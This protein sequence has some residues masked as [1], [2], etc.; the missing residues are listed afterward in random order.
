MM[1]IDHPSTSDSPMTS[2]QQTL[3]SQ[4]NP[5]KPS[6]PSQQDDTSLSTTKQSESGTPIAEPSNQQQSG[7]GAGAIV[8]HESPATTHQSADETVALSMMQVDHPV[9]SSST[10]D[11]DERE[12]QEMLRE[13]DE[14]GVPQ[15]N[16]LQDIEQDSRQDASKK[17]TAIMIT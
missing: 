8:E 4:P 1:Q 10:E 12:I 9:A 16:L 13:L 3:S 17:R 14:I 11:D 7:R 5:I 15:T 6:F 2:N